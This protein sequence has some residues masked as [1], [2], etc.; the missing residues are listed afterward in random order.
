MLGSEDITNIQE[1]SVTAPASSSKL[2][3]LAKHA[4]SQA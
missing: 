4:I 2:A 1:P 3:P